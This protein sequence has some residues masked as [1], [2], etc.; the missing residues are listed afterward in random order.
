[1]LAEYDRQLNLFA[2][3]HKWTSADFTQ[4]LI[5]QGLLKPE[6]APLECA[7]RGRDESPLSASLSGLKQAINDCIEQSSDLLPYERDQL[8]AELI[9]AGFPSLLELSSRNIG[10][11][12]DAL[13][14]GT[15]RSE[16]E[17]YLAAELLSQVDLE[18]EGIDKHEI[19]VL[20]DQF[21]EKHSE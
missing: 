18:I 10:K 15:I 3:L 12:R 4:Q 5:S 2:V 8:N 21:A 20:A 6:D 13:K 9:S 19:A 11:L 16:E 17:Y 14:R 1:M 7:R